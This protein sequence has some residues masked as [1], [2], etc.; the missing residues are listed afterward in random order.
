MDKSAQIP[1]VLIAM[2][3]AQRAAEDEKALLVSLVRNL[4][5]C[6]GVHAAIGPTISLTAARSGP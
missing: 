1:G 2:Q 4:I 5:A 6:W 3:H